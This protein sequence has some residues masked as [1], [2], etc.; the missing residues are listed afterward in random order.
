MRQSEMIPLSFGTHDGTFHADEVTACALLL[1]FGLIERGKIFRSRSAEQLACCEFVCDVGGVYDASKKRFDHHQVDYS[2]SLSSAGLILR[3]LLEQ[4][5]LSQELF[6]HLQKT[7]IFGVDTHDNGLELAPAGVC[8]YS[9]I[10]AM[11]NPAEHESPKEAENAAFFEALDFAAGLL[12]K[13]IHRFHYV[14]ECRDLVERAMNEGKEYLVFDKNI[15]WLENFFALGGEHHP[16]KYLIMP[17]HEHWKLRA[18]PPSYED[19]MNVRSPLP[20]SWAGLLNEDLEKSSGI[21]GAI[22]CHKGLFVSV[23]K[24]KE[25]VLKALKK[26][27]NQQ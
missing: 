23:W 10:I 27:L 11:Y 5:K 2:G 15:P 7:L 14:R 20:I 9:H 22:F 25:A 17:S 6:D 1:L 26:A 21:E 4:G 19:K 13:A 24:T 3:Y 16:A 12:K 8:T 18:I